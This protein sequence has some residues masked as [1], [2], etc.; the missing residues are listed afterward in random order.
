MGLPRS[1]CECSFQGL[2]RPAAMAQ[3]QTTYHGR[4]RRKRGRAVGTM[5]RENVLSVH[6]CTDSGP[7]IHM[8][9]RS[10]KIV[11]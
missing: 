4:K 3:A 2:A 5:M 11:K 9:D 7:L 8:V 1:Q 10:G 6:D